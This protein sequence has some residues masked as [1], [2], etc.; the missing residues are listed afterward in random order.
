MIKELYIVAATIPVILPADLPK[1]TF[2]KIVS[3]PADSGSSMLSDFRKGGKTEVEELTGDIVRLGSK[4]NIPTPIYQLMYNG[5]I[6]DGKH[7]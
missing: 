3:L 1:T 2:E 7:I 6:K 4:L 5:L